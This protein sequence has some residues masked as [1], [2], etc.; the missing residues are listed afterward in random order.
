MGA[1]RISWRTA[2]VT[3]AATLIA[4]SGAGTAS[5]VAYRW[6]MAQA[7]AARGVIGRDTSKPPEADGIYT[8][9]CAAPEPWRTGK[10]ADLHLMIF[11]DSTAAGVGCADAEGVP[12]VRIAR[13]LTEATGKRIRLSTKA[14]SGATSKGLAGQVDAMF[15]AGPPPDAAV[16]FV[17]A[18]D[19]TKKHSISASARRLGAAV[20]RL[21]L[22]GS[23]VVV[24]TCPDLGTVAAIPQPLRTIVHNWSVRLAK[25]QFAVTTAAGGHPVQMGVL[26]REFLAAP[27]EMFS[28]DGFHPS[29]AGYELAAAQI[30]P[31]LLE[32]LERRGVD[33]DD[34]AARAR[35][36]LAAR[37]VAMVAQK[38]AADAG[39]RNGR[40]DVPGALH[41]RYT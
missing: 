14:I 33:T 1:P 26:G 7:G 22:A 38:P 19:I 2:A 15:V 29:A 13:A 36:G 10:H 3:G 4:G 40:G 37:L 39:A 8:A 34:G 35:R 12:G 20:A 31:V 32:A 30:L 27:D 41:I 18:N 28:A 25:A 24:G 23:V 11:G 21:H 6:L 16:I 9:G 17:G 5:W